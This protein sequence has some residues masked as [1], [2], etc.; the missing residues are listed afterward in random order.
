MIYSKIRRVIFETVSKYSPGSATGYVHL[1]VSSVKQIS[2]RA[3]R[4]GLSDGGDPGG[5]CTTLHANDH[6][7]L[8]QCLATPY[9]PL[10]FSRIGPTTETVTAAGT[11]LPPKASLSTILEAHHCIGRIPTFMRYATRSNFE[12]FDYVDRYWGDMN[13]TD[14]VLLLF[15]PIPWRDVVTTQIIKCFLDM[16]HESMTVDFMEGIKETG[17]LQTMLKVEK[18]M[19]AEKSP[20][21]TVDAMLR[22]ESFHKVI[23][24]YIWMTFRSPVVY[25]EF[26]MVADLKHRLEKVLNWSLEGLSKNQK[27]KGV[28]SRPMASAKYLSREDVRL[29]KDKG[30]KPTMAFNPPQNVAPS[31]PIAG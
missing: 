27:P 14:R 26:L 10:E 20:H 18:D 25:S 30:K 15:A 6:S 1:S 2:G 17:Y 4:Y 23:V 5:S 19:A 31:P 13:V 29:G 21:S 28:I 9:S 22:L 12:V 24:F 7:Y 11:V 8:R 16:H 3:G